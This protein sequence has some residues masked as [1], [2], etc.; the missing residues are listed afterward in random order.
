MTSG[1]VDPCVRPTCMVC[2]EPLHRVGLA[3]V[4]DLDFVVL[5]CSRWG[6]E[7]RLPGWVPGTLL[8]GLVLRWCQSPLERLEAFYCVRCASESLKDLKF[9]EAKANKMSL[10]WVGKTW[11]FEVPLHDEEG[12]RAFSEALKEG[13]LFPEDPLEAPKE[14]KAGAV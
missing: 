2:R 6:R 5:I 10:K 9:E 11:S 3:G 13:A 7:R 14:G 1:G 8:P 4:S 12:W